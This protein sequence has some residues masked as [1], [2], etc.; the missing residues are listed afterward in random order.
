M[1]IQSI[2]SWILRLAAASAFVIG[3]SAVGAPSLEQVAAGV[4]IDP[5]QI[6]VSGISSGGFMAHQFHVAHSGHVMGAGIVAG[7]PYYCAA[8]SILDAVTKCSQFV[9]LE[10]KKLPVDPA[11]CGKTDLSPKN[12]KEVEDAAGLAFDEA[13]RQAARGRIDPLSNLQGD[14]V[15]LFSGIYDSIVPQG[16]MDTLYRFYADADKAGL[17]P[18]NIHYSHHFPAPHTMVRDGFDKPAGGAVGD[19]Q[20]GGTKSFTQS[21]FIDNCEAVARHQEERDQCICP[22]MG[23]GGGPAADCPPA[24]RQ[25]V[26]QDLHDVDLAGAI[27]GRIYGSEALK[28]GRTP[29]RGAQVQ[30]FDQRQVFNALSPHPFNALQDASMAKEG[31]IFIPEA[32]KKGRTCRLHV[33]FHG[34]LQGGLTGRKFKR[35]GNLF[36]QFA[37]YNEWAQANE[38]VMLYPQVEVHQGSAPMNP[39]GCW[40]WWGQNYTHEGYHTQRGRQIKAVARMIN[41]LADD[42]KLLPLP[43]D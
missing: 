27:L 17:E 24:D 6:S 5:S 37:G 8:G 25:T 40:D 16:V 43:P 18:T 12:E 22:A 2:I 10:C 29:V 31:Y 4:K 3:G 26:C 28:G 19:C 33:A 42:D 34:C 13:R 38:I 1:S 35:P 11:W 14:R 41:I 15:Y 39:Q 9:L 32:C 20:S 21:T 36:S 23:P 30:A 7:G